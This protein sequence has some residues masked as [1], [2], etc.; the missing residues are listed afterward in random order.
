MYR[1][2]SEQ[3][4]SEWLQI[5]GWFVETGVPLRSKSRG[6]RDEADIV[7][8]KREE[9]CLTVQHIEVGT[10]AGGS[11]KDLATMK[12]KF[13]PDKEKQIVNYV[14]KRLGTKPKYK[15][16]YI[17]T[18]VSKASQRK[19]QENGYRVDWLH[20][21][22][23]NEILPAITRWKREEVKSRKTSQLP[24]PP[25]NLWMIQLLNYMGYHKIDLSEYPKK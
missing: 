18:Y 13:S 14:E 25:N 10:L 6:G 16:R 3:V 19:L 4:V 7:A 2:F 23:Q 24:T 17:A 20:D 11:Q 5:E 22:I 8:I 9:G 15:C 1:T 12:K 21:V